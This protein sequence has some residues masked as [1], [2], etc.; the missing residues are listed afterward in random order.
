MKNQNFK[1]KGICK[2]SRYFLHK[3]GQKVRFNVL[4]TYLNLLFD[5]KIY[6]DI[7]FSSRDRKENYYQ[8]EA[9][10]DIEN[11]NK[12][13][14]KYGMQGRMVVITGKTTFLNIIRIS[15]LILN[16]KNF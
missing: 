11:T 12:D 16:N 2:Y 4:E 14:L 3:V 15:Y 6:K 8:I 5:W 10:T 7:D 13:L 9:K 1:S